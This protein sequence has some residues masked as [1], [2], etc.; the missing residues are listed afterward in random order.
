MILSLQDAAI[1]MEILQLYLRSLMTYESKDGYLR[2]RLLS[3][4]LD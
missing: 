4:L 1:E 3:H 2:Q